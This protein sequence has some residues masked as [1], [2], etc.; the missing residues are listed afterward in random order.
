[1]NTFTVDPPL[2]RSLLTLKGLTVIRDAGGEAIG[3]FSPACSDRSKAYSQAA[4]HFD[5]DEMNRRK[6]QGEP[7]LTT[8]EVLE[9]LKSLEP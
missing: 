4:A 2:A 7:G 5:A 1:M 8:A 9:R 3:Y 6:G